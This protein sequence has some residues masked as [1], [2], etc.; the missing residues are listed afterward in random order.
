MFCT[1]PSSKAE[2]WWV[3]PAPRL[4]QALPC[5]V[6]QQGTQTLP[7]SLLVSPIPIQFKLAS[8]LQSLSRK[9]WQKLESAPQLIADTSNVLITSD[10]VFSGAFCLG[11]LPLSTGSITRHVCLRFI[12]CDL[13]WHSSWLPTA[14]PGYFTLCPPWSCWDSFGSFCSIHR[15]ASLAVLPCHTCRTGNGPVSHR[16]EGRGHCLCSAQRMKRT[17]TNTTAFLWCSE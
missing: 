14:H 3:Y 2:C 12:A 5:F 16:R 8:Y 11:G 17:N 7:L 13:W 6:K 9:S 4:S 10:H 15:A 1:W